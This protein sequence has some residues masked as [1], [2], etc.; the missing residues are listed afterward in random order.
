MSSGKSSTAGR[1]KAP[2]YVLALL[3]AAYV[4]NFLD[5]QLLTLLLNDIKRD[6]GLSD[7]QLG[8]AS[9]TSFALLYVIASVPVAHLADRWN[10]LRLL[11]ICIA[12]WS[13]MTAACGAVRTFPQ[14][15][16]A[17]MGV[18]IG[19][20][21]GMPASLS[22][23]ADLFPRSVRATK[24]GIYFAA[25]AVGTMLSYVVGG[26]ANVLL[27]WRM[28]FFLFAAP[29]IILALLI[30]FTTS[31]PPRGLYDEVADAPADTSLWRALGRLWAMP[32]FRWLC[33]AYAGANF[34]MYSL[35]SWVP[36]LALRVFELDTA[37]VGLVL[38][39][40]TG[41]VVGMAQIMAGMIA[42]R[43]A[44]RSAAAPLYLVALTTAAI[45]V[46]IPLCLFA[47]TFAGLAIGFT[48]CYALGGIYSTPSIAALQAQL[49]P[50]LRAKAA[51][52]LF[53]LGTLAGLGIGP[54]VVGALSDHFAPTHGGG[55]LR[56]A[57]LILSPV[58]LLTALLFFM[59]GLRLRKEALAHD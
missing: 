43:L 28:T 12:L 56:Y 15:L 2:N 42:D 55:S 7:Q 32:L 44:R 4:L 38:G 39:V 41:F 23:I 21:G 53:M 50:D 26:Y 49:P 19:E 16:L 18:A 9:G 30:H 46:L 24:L 14:L 25:A 52:I 47:P 3:F 57:L 5:R 8:L 45:A 17:R 48:A 11:A 51:A 29:G 35:I 40:L 27:G 22:L 6:L 20:S 31:E 36:A 34:S 1:I 13:V 54:A 37:T 10:R 59:A 58:A 33:L